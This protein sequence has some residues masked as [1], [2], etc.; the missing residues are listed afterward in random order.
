LYEAELDDFSEA[1]A[2]IADKTLVNEEDA[3]TID[4]AWTYSAGTTVQTF[5]NIPNSEGDA[6]LDAAGKIAGDGVDDAIAYHFGAGG[7]IAG[8]AQISGILVSEIAFDPGTWYDT[9]TQV[10]LP[11]IGDEAPNGIIIDEWLCVCNVDPDVEIDA[12]LKYADSW[13]GLANPVTVDA[14][15]TTNGASSEDTDANI[16]SGSAIP[17]GKRLYLEFDADPEGTCTTMI[18]S[19]RFH[20]E[21]D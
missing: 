14:I 6:T 9:D 11:S 20:Y 5:L 2:Q 15:D 16:N 1:Q 21:E 18:F 13:H 8:E 17:N 4:S 3:A 10:P 7:E 12:N 19:L